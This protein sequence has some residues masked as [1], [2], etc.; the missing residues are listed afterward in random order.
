MMCAPQL[1]PS[2]PQMNPSQVK[3]SKDI[4]RRRDAGGDRTHC[5]SQGRETGLTEKLAWRG[6]PP[7]AP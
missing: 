1:T 3:K 6:K 4:E 7:K 2:S 5:S